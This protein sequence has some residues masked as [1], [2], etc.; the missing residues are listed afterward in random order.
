MRAAALGK[1]L[2]AQVAFVFLFGLEVK[3]EITAALT[4]GMEMITDCSFVVSAFV[5]CKLAC[6]LG[7]VGHM[8][9]VQT[10]E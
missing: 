8:L 3:V 1:I 10:G 6:L 2:A 4:V 5:W 9:R 7:W